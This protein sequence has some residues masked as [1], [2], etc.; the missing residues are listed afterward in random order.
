MNTQCHACQRWGRVR[1][2]PIRREHPKEKRRAKDPSREEAKVVGQR[3]KARK[4]VEDTRTRVTFA[5][6]LATSR[7]IA[8]SMAWGA[9]GVDFHSSEEIQGA[10]HRRGPRH[11][12]RRWVVS[13]F[14]GGTSWPH[15]TR[16]PQ[17]G[18]EETTPAAPTATITSSSTSR[19]AERLR[20]SAG[21]GRRSSQRQ[22]GG[23]R[24]VRGFVPHAA[25]GGAGGR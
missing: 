22:G 6:R 18:Q 12:E 7:G 21:R 10:F 13:G 3:R 17:T 8:P 1:R 14:W 11:R 4:E 19:L 24:Y 2:P 23:S 5:N 20:V 15:T 16:V 9:N 25:P